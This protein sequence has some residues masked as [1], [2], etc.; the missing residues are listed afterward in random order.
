MNCDLPELINQ[1]QT[2]YEAALKNEAGWEPF[3]VTWRAWDD[4]SLTVIRKW[5]N[6]YTFVVVEIWPPENEE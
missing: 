5:P 4:G 1:L 3:E 6:G 2:A